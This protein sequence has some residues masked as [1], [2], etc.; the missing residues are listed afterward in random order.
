MK[1]YRLQRIKDKFNCPS[2]EKI[3]SIS[4][5]DISGNQLRELSASEFSKFL[6]H[7]D[8]PL[9]TLDLGGNE[10]GRGNLRNFNLGNLPKARNLDLSGNELAHKTANEVAEFLGTISVGV[11]SVNLSV[12]QFNRYSADELITILSAL[13]KTVTKMNLSGNNLGNM[14][15]GEL[16]KFLSKI[17]EHIVELDLCWN[18]FERKKIDEQVRVLSAIPP[19]VKAL[20]TSIK[21]R[22]AVDQ[23][24][25]SLIKA[26]L[27]ATLTS[28]S[29]HWANLQQVSTVQVREA[30]SQLPPNLELRFDSHHFGDAKQ[31]IIEKLC[32]ALPDNIRHFYLSNDEV[33]EPSTVWA[34]LLTRKVQEVVAREGSQGVNFEQVTLPV[35][36]NQGLFNRL[37]KWYE[38]KN[39]GLS[40]LICGL[41]AQGK[42]AS[43]NWGSDRWATTE[44]RMHDALSFY[45]R[46]G[47]VDPNLRS[48]V[49]FL[50]WEIKTTTLFDSV[51]NRLR[52]AYWAPSEKHVP[53]YSIFGKKAP[54]PVVPLVDDSCWLYDKK[55]NL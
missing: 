16:I 52:Q 9:D 13:P 27:K 2:P 7:F 32:E 15:T 14:D 10:F 4:Y 21:I 55:V 54:P 24:F 49:E 17:P 6:S 45:F 23:S 34:E 43:Y 35:N 20:K 18:N 42:I 33:V 25:F 51:K 12:N 30:L 5:L 41:L 8:H 48:V 29:I 3:A 37:I 26:H 39:D 50:V 31:A 47:T 40:L 28:L 1:Y 11:D 36:I 22:N 38:K 19:S 53:S 46:A 44:K